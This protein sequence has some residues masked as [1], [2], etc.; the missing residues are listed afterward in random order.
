MGINDQS[1]LTRDLESERSAL[2]SPAGGERLHARAAVPFKVRIHDEWHRV[3]NIGLGGFAVRHPYPVQVSTLP[4]V[5]ELSLF[6]TD[7]TVAIS[8]PVRE[9]WNDVRGTRSFEFMSLTRHQA[10][11]LN[12]L[13]EDFLARQVTVIDNLIEPVGSN[14]APSG[15]ESSMRRRSLPWRGAMLLAVS[16]FLALLAAA[17][18]FSVRSAIAAV[19]VAGALLRAPAAGVLEGPSLRPGSIVHAGD[20]L[21][22]IRTPGGVAQTAAADGEHER[23][24]MA[25]QQQQMQEREVKGLADQLV[26][27]SRARIVSLKSKRSAV[28]LQINA[29]RSLLQRMQSMASQGFVSGLQVEN[30]KIALGSLLKSR[31]EVAEE[32][33]GAESQAMLA[34]SGSLRTDLTNSTQTR[35]N[36]RARIDAAQLAVTTTERKLDALGAATSITSPCDCVVR[37]VMATP[38]EIVAAG[39]LVYAL[40]PR[41]APPEIAA[42]VASDRVHELRPGAFAII[43]LPDRWIKGRLL[44][45]SYLG[46]NAARIGLPSRSDVVGNDEVERMATAIIRPDESI[47][48]SQIGSPVRAY[49]ASNPLQAAFARFAMVFR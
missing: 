39:A 17:P 46:A 41:T 7:V 42:L 26:A 36:M 2:P 18:I 28:D 21:F 15:G 47:D 35:E 9:V 48:A 10:A 45:I 38:G 37:A 20:A 44:S 49:M 8:V 40:S 4:T 14:A 12:R 23:L 16:G 29:A 34:S 30:Q 31:A 33:I 25:L 22:H 19:S 6:L 43:A 27:S 32:L 5:V 3:E 1:T 11:L 24:T 13:V